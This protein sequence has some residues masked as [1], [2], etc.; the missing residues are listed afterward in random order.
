MRNFW[1]NVQF[2]THLPI[3]IVYSYFLIYPCR[4]WNKYRYDNRLCP[5]TPDI[6][7]SL[8]HCWGIAWAIHLYVIKVIYHTHVEKSLIAFIDMQQLFAGESPTFI[9][10]GYFPVE[11]E[12]ASFLQKSAFLIPQ[13]ATGAV[14][15][16][17]SRLLYVMF[18]REIP[19]A[20]CA[21]HPA[22]SN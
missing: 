9:T 5:R 4:N 13:S 14:R 7:T 16:S 22:R 12:W 6:A 10:I 15:Y 18:S 11:K 17:D 8:S 2:V 19:A 21:I 1:L 3:W 20:Y